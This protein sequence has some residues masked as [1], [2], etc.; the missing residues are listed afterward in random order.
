MAKKI[1]VL[2]PVIVAAIIIGSAG[3]V[4]V[5]SNIKNT[6][7]KFHEGKVRINNDEIKVEVA[8]TPPE[9][10]RWLMFREEKTYHSILQ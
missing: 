5:P 2:I 8:K 7:I 10:Q 4:F 1:T 6:S 3:L 9:K